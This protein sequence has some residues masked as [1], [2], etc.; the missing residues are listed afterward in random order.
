[1]FFKYSWHSY[2]GGL[3]ILALLLTLALSSNNALG[4]DATQLLLPEILNS[5]DVGRYQRIF[6]LQEDGHWN[7]A[8]KLIVDTA[9]T[10]RTIHNAY[11]NNSGKLHHF[12]TLNTVS[13][14]QLTK[15]LNLLSNVL[16]KGCFA[17]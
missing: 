7:K 9:C 2:K 1:M 14:A 3:P 15:A 6:E 11:A 16:A 5:H 10:L 17:P 13:C 12:L 4:E 8:N